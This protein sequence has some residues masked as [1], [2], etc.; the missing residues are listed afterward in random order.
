MVA[1]TVDLLVL[2]KIEFHPTITKAQHERTQFS[3]KTELLLNRLY[4][5]Q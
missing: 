2:T 3:E 4:L 1:L 5:S